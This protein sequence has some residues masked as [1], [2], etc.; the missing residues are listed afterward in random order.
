[1]GE[2]FRLSPKKKGLE[3]TR[4]YHDKKIIKDAR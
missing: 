4:V 3:D 1:M 2:P